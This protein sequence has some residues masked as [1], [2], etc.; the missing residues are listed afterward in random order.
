MIPADGPGRD[1]FARELL[2]ELFAAAVASADPGR[3]LAGAL[4]EKPAGRCV[5]VGAGK[6]AAVMAR[7][8]FVSRM[9]TPLLNSPVWP[10]RLPSAMPPAP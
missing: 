2:A 10:M 3:V 5:V 7:S 4:P 1:L 8:P 6:S 9:K